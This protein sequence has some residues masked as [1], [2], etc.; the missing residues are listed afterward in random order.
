MT[1]LE[2]SVGAMLVPHHGEVA[3]AIVAMCI[4]FAICYRIVKEDR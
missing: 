3:I 4:Y 2:T 1:I